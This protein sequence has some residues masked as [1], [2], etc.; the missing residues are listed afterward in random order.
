MSTVAGTMM[1]PLAVQS[2]HAWLTTV[3]H[4]RGIAGSVDQG[5]K[6][7]IGQPLGH[8]VQDLSQLTAECS[9]TVLT[10]LVTE[11]W[12]PNP[13]NLFQPPVK[14]GASAGVST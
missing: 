7:Q 8:G 4:E 11:A 6:R 3:Q 9:Q 10:H 5:Q 12:S 2:V 14:I 13:P 1:A